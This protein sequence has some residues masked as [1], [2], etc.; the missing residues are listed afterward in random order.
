M[1]FLKAKNMVVKKASFSL[2]KLAD[3]SDSGI[4]C[5]GFHVR[6]NSKQNI[7]GGHC[8]KVHMHW[9]SLL[10]KMLAIRTCVGFLG[11]EMILFVSPRP[12]WSRQ[13]VSTVDVA[14]IFAI[15]TS[16]L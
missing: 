3:D 10:A 13:V 11:P 14:D 6:C 4:T 8:L 12:R 5:L 7:F 9:R 1:K 2:E 16:P 15:K